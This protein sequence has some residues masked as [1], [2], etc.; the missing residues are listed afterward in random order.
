MFLINREEVE[1]ISRVDGV[2]LQLGAPGEIVAALDLERKRL[3]HR[4]EIEDGH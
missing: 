4:F 1:L 3:E 2:A